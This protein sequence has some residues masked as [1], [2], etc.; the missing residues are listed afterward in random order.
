MTCPADF[1]TRCVVTSLKP[2]FAAPAAGAT[3]ARDTRSGGVFWGI[4]CEANVAV[5]VFLVSWALRLRW[6]VF[7][8]RGWKLPCCSG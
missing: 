7:G 8:V 2:S 3:E 1:V 6:L 4:W 5:T